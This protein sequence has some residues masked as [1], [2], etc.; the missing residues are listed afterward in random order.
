MDVRASVGEG[1]QVEGEETDGDVEEFAR[2]LVFVYLCEQW[3]V[4]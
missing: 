3:D 4:S 2:D 1:V